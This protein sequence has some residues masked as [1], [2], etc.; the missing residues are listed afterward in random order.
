MSSSIY[1]QKSELDTSR[2]Y[3]SKFYFTWKKH[4][5][6]IWEGPKML[7]KPFVTASAPSAKKIKGFYS[8]TAFWRVLKMSLKSSCVSISV[9]KAPKGWKTR[10]AS[11]VP[12]MRNGYLCP[13]NLYVAFVWTSF[14]SASVSFSHLIVA[15]KWVEHRI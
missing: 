12:R 3:F 10:S 4:I 14:W 11:L 2:K 1:Q 6:R 8:G 9:H 7:M 13:F 5:S 15:A